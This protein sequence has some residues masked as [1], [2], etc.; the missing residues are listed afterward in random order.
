VTSVILTKVFRGFAQSL[1]VNVEI[2]LRLSYDRMFSNHH[3]PF[4]PL[5]DVIQSRK[6]KRP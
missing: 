4:I 2:L 6:L 3:S 5:L 1:R